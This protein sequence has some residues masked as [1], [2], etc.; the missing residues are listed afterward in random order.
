MV[1]FTQEINGV[2][3]CSEWNV[4]EDDYDYHQEIARSGFA[5][6]LHDTERNQKYFI[7]LKAAI[8]KMHEAGKPANVL[9]IG[10]IYISIITNLL[11][12]IKIYIVPF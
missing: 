6:M 11:M 10:K 8:D 1:V 9:D 7:A 3:G 12:N 4:H 2:I 5:D